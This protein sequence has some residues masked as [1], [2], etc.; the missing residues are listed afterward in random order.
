MPR[1][2]LGMVGYLKQIYVCF[3]PAMDHLFIVG[4]E[5][6]SVVQSKDWER[7]IGSIERGTSDL[8]SPFVFALPE[9]Y[10]LS[11]THQYVLRKLRQVWCNIDFQCILSFVSK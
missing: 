7:A 2:N 3:T 1:S 4:R 5:G 11:Y 9:I 10:R 8:V 6:Y